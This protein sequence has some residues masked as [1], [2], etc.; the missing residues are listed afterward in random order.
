M[1]TLNAIGL[2]A[3]LAVGL[4]FVG[5]SREAADDADLAAPDLSTEVGSPSEA[6][7]G[8]AEP[9]EGVGEAEADSADS[10]AESKPA[11][12]S[13]DSAGTKPEPAGKPAAE[14]PAESQPADAPAGS[15]PEAGE[16]SAG[17]PPSGPGGPREGR[18]GR[19][20]ERADADGDGK[21][22]KDE[23]PERMREHLLEAD[24]DGDGA[25]TREELDAA[26]ERGDWGPRGGRGRGGPGAGS[27]T[28]AQ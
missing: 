4:A 14:A 16:Q 9:A 1:R 22:T 25:V 26:R 27:E 20:F 13:S 5:C 19:L 23:M 8:E 10:P 15:Q 21:L 24:A 3:L 11:E 7:A 12:A 28:E 17:G 2:I 6:S 18:R